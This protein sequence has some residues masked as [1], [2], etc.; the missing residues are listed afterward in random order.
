MNFP[1]CTIQKV[2]CMLLPA[3]KHRITENHII[4]V[5]IKEQWHSKVENFGC[6]EIIFIIF[7]FYSH[8]L[9]CQDRSFSKLYLFRPTSNLYPFSAFPPLSHILNSWLFLFFSLA[10]SLCVT[11]SLPLLGIS[12]WPTASFSSFWSHTI[13]SKLFLLALLIIPPNPHFAHPIPFCLL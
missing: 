11:R 9:K 8:W 4:C 12:L 7:T 10:G 5:C 1:H 13:T 2:C 6:H 3:H